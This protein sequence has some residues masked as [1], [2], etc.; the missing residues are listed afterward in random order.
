[1]QNT[2]SYNFYA[3]VWE[4]IL[5]EKSLNIQGRHATPSERAAPACGTRWEAIIFY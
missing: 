3:M 4:Q 1:M 5:L 2:F